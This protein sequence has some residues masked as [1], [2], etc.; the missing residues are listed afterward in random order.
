[1]FRL[2]KIKVVKE[3]LY[4]LWC[5]KKKINLWDDSVDNIVT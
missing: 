2:D 3:K 4:G 5:K 1:M